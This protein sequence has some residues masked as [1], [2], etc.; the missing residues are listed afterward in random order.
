MISENFARESW[1]SPAAA[2]GK[3][4]RQFSTDAV[5]GSDWRGQ[6]VRHDGVDQKAP[7]IVYWPRD[8]QES[9]Y[10]KATIGVQR[11]VTFAV[12]S[13]N[14][15]TE[16]LLNEMQQA[17]WSVNGNLPVAS[18]RTMQEIYG[19]RWRGRRSRW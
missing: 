2:I 3:R 17:V 14:A 1:G 11:A 4:I 9:L 8:D 12:R 15:G 13:A 5:A 10:A 16:G 19:R 6:D 18:P 7:A